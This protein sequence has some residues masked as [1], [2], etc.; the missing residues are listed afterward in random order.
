MQGHRD[1]IVWQ[2]AMLL[3]TD[4]YQATR[5][6]PKDDYGLTANFAGPLFLC[7]AISPKNMD[8]ARARTFTASSVKRAVP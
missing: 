2:K 4:I 7:P 5:N 1:L 8:E 3:V 6:F